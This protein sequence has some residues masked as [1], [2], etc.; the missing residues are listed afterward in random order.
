VGQNPFEVWGDG[1]QI[2]N[3]TYIDDIVSG[4]I[5]AAEKID[6]G[7]AVNLG[8]MERVRVIDAVKEVLRYTGHRA[9]IKLRPDM[10]TGPLNRVADNS[11]A[12]KLLGWEPKVRFIDGL[13][14]TIDW[15]FAT[16]DRAQ[17]KKILDRML[18]ER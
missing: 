18:T 9:E 17:V 1:T 13:H 8:T 10:P 15:Y 14:R 6:D 2:R 12:K 16:K 7:T 4:T 3:W 5:L 11:L